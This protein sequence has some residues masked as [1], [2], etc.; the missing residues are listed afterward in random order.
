MK[1]RFLS[2]LLASI[3]IVGL[4]PISL[5]T[6]NAW[7]LSTPQYI[8]DIGVAYANKK[9][10]ESGND[11]ANRAK[12][13]L[14]G[15]G[16]TA[17]DQDLNEDAGGAYIYMGYKTSTDYSRAITGIFF[18]VGD[19]NN[20][21]DRYQKG[22]TWFYLVGGSYEGN[23]TGD[24]A[25]DLNEGAGGKYIY[26]YVTRDTNYDGGYPLMEIFYKYHDMAVDGKVAQNFNGSSQNL[27][28]GAKSSSKSIYL[29]YK[30]FAEYTQRDEE[31]HITYTTTLNITFYYL[32][33]G[34]NLQSTT[35]SK[36]VRNHEDKFTVSA[37]DVPQ[38]VTVNGYTLSFA[39]WRSD[40]NGYDPQTTEFSTTFM[41]GTGFEYKAKVAYAVYSGNVTVSYD[42]NGGT[43][44]PAAQTLTVKAKAYKSNTM[45]GT[46]TFTLSSTKP[47]NGSLHDFLG[48]ST[49]KNATTAQYKA[50]QKVEFKKN[51]TLYA[52]YA[53]HPYSDKWTSNS[54][55]HWHDSTCNHSAITG[56]SAHDYKDATCTQ[57]KTCKVCGYQTGSALGHDCKY[58]ASGNVITQT[59]TRCSHRETATIM[60]T[61]SRK[62][63]GSALEPCTVVYS[64]GWYGA[65]NYELKYK[66]NVSVGTAT[67]YIQ[68]NGVYA[69]LDF[70][71]EKGVMS[72]IWASGENV[73]YD[74]KEHCITVHGVPEGAKV[75]YQSPSTLGDGT[76]E[77]DITT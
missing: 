4:I 52:V 76:P 30:T 49:D 23:G 41:D 36:T 73:T 44:A 31:K 65:K 39:G 60:V 17:I 7:S 14:T 22:S 2:L 38:T 68:Q 3:M 19:K 24:G 45:N 40:Y 77:E 10:S 35:K 29:N 8:T 46:A 1:K 66:N 62:Y 27:N 69:Y 43:G 15:N 32:D 48:W 59:C 61:G 25:V 74:G 47:V 26:L 56:Y 12:K 33:A 72:G 13:L 71:I 21:P 6:A 64:S 57:P 16:Y 63:T 18:W 11:A 58:S 50:G 28:E 34:G 42:A 67:C 75:Y 54:T 9:I 37:A 70:T 53:T 20:K 5:L 55:H 51:T